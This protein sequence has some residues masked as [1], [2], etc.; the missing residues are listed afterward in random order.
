MA[1]TMSPASHK[2]CKDHPPLSS[3]DDFHGIAQL[4]LLSGL[5]ERESK[6]FCLASEVMFSVEKGTCSEPD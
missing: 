1:P 3:V 6:V 2:R 4:I 5:P